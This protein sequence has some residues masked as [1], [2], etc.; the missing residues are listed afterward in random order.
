MNMMVLRNAQGLH[1]PLRL[2]MELRSAKKVGRL[3]FL[4][5]SNVMY[6]S[7]TGKDW[8][9]GPE[10]RFNTSEFWEVSGQPHAVVE[11]SLNIL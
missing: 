9:I 1:A 3:P 6:D 4:A 7:L 5:S 10:D 2:A 8:D 11:K